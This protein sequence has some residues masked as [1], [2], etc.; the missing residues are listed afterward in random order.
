LAKISTTLLSIN[1][2]KLIFSP[3]HDV[4]AIYDPDFE[5]PWLLATLLML[6]PD[7]VKAICRDHWP[8]EQVP[9]SAKRRSTG[10]LFWSLQ[11]AETKVSQRP[12]AK[13]AGR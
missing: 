1:T 6:N 12:A 9:L 5:Q 4:Y 3:A 7:R 11:L 2:R 10:C 8:V 13:A